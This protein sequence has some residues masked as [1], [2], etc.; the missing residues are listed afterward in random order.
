MNPSFG[1]KLASAAQSNPA[2]ELQEATAAESLKRKEGAESSGVA[3][4]A[5]VPMESARSHEDEKQAKVESSTN[6]KD[7]A[8]SITAELKTSMKES[9]RQD[10]VVDASA[11]SAPVNEEQA[12]TLSRFSKHDANSRPQRGRSE[13]DRKRSSRSPSPHSRDQKRSRRSNSPRPR[14]SAAHN[15]R[16]AGRD[17]ADAGGGGRGRGAAERDRRG[18]ERQRGVQDYKHTGGGPRDRGDRRDH[19]SRSRSRSRTPPKHAQGSRSRTRSRSKSPSRAR[20][21]SR[22]L[23][24]SP[25]RR[26]KAH[27]SRSRSRSPSR[28]PHSDQESDF[29]SRF[30]SYEE[31]EAFM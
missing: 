12:L 25:P 4:N 20:A 29:Y 3:E 18:G 7:E 6:G 21:R 15:G 8:A 24:R 11:Q 26:P 23:S 2:S 19:R 28:S 13:E 14:D 5:P 22:S 9:Q 27:S 31:Y 30:N 17:G 10:S 16:G 1:D